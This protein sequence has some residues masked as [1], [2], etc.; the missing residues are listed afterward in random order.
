MPI[1]MDEPA[2][3]GMYEAVDGILFAGGNDVNPKLYNKKPLAIRGDVSKDVSELRDS[4][5]V[6]LMKWALADKKPMLLICRGMQLINVVCGGSLY[7]HLPE[8]LPKGEDHSL[9]IKAQDFFE[10]AHTLKVDPASRLHAILGSTDIEVNSLHHQGIE[11][12]APNLKAVAWSKD[13]IIEAIEGT[14]GGYVI[15]VQSHPEA[16]E[17]DIVPAWRSL[18]RSF[19]E[20]SSR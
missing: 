13:G 15:G 18:F 9:S 4:Y 14:N 5:E 1:T 19:V 3:R 12:L 17:A 16:L 8:D 2:L 10:L 7:Q 20:A 11:K 6:Q